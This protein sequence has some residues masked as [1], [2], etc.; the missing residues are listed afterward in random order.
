LKAG[1][2]RPILFKYTVTAHRPILGPISYS[3]AD[4]K[5]SKTTSH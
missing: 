2:F 5:P 1:R 4:T 3:A